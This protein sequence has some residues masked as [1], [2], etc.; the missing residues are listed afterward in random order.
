MKSP[1]CMV[2]HNGLFNNTNCV[3]GRMTWFG[4]LQDDKK[5]QTTFLNG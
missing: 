1:M 5:K 2:T 3:M 4:G